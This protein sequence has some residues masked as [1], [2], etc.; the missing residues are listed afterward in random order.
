MEPGFSEAFSLETPRRSPPGYGDASGEPDLAQLQSAA[1]TASA[2][3]IMIT[4][5]NGSVVWVNPAFCSLSGYTAAEVVGRNPRDLVKS[6]RHRPEEYQHLWA[7]ILS[8]K[9]WQGELLNRRKDGT[10]Y[11]EYQTIT[12][13]CDADLKIT[14]FIAIKQD[15]TER[16]KAAADLGEANARYRMLFDQAPDGIVLIDEATGKFLEFNDAAHRLLEYSRAE[17]ATL[18]IADVENA[19]SAAEV[20]RHIAAIVREGRDDFDTRFRTRRGAIRQVHVTAQFTRTDG[21]GVFH[22]VWRDITERKAAEGTMREQNEILASSREGVMIV[23]LDGKI[24]LWN[25]GASEI[26]GWP[27]AEALG[28][29]PEQVL[30]LDNPGALA[31]VRAAIQ[32]Q[33]FWNGVLPGQSRDHRRLMVE[34]RTS[35]ARDEAGLP[36]GR[37]TFVTDITER[38]QL[39]EKFLQAQRLENI[40]MLAAGIAH[41]LNNVLAPIVFAG[42]LLRGSLSTPR[43]LQI[44]DILEKSAARGA[45]LVQQILGFSRGTSGEFQSTQV[46][47]LARDI[48]E[49]IQATFPKSIRLEH[50][51]PAELWPVLGDPTQLHQVLLN[52]CVNARDAMPQGGTL[53]IA[54]QNLEDAE[55]ARM[56]PGGPPGSWLKLEISDTGTGIAPEILE[57]IWTPFFTTKGLSQGTGLGLSTVRGIVTRHQGFIELDTAVG[58]GTTFRIFLPAFRT[59]SP[60]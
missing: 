8:G 44:V 26:F 7:T 17:F 35:L 27:A 30:G 38:K 51:L 34:F 2:N 53:R 3:A 60:R 39:E 45:G 14:H 47:H 10:L 40:G 18:S 19:E 59:E 52:L 58:H 20:G 15:L 48:L 43:D 31:A 29:T 32:R 25:R 36:R 1:V 37:I 56:V 11:P 5:R 4:D 23:G 24:R 54:A 57:R 6:G 55:A 9:T 42:P 28:R 21:R 13:V 33:G 22:S 46:K 50:H 12:P 16:K 49:I 41:D